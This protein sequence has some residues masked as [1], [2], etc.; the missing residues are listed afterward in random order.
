MKKRRTVLFR[1]LVLA[2]FARDLV[3]EKGNIKK[4]KKGGGK[5]KS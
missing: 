2:V 5:I 3:R 4:A 1:D